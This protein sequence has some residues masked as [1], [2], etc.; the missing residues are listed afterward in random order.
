MSDGELL[1]L[2]REIHSDVKRIKKYVDILEAVYQK[3]DESHG[4]GFNN[5]R[6]YENG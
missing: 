1:I 3:G 2:V 4:H 6:R 5:T